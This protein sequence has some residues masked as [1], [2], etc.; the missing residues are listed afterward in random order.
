MVD[1][2][3]GVARWLTFGAWRDWVTTRVARDR[4]YAS[5]RRSARAA[6]IMPTMFALG[7]KVI[8]NPAI[9]TFAAFGS[10]AML[11][12]VDFG[13]S[14][15]DRMLAT[16][17]LGAAGCVLVALATLASRHAGTAALSMGIVAF[18]VLF[19]GVISSVLAGASTAL[20]LSIILPVTQ[21]ADPSV[22]PDRIAGW[23][24]AAAV[25]TIAVGV[26]WPSP[27]NDPLRATAV[28]ACRALGARLRTDSACRLGNATADAHAVTV[29]TALEAIEALRRGFLATPYR[30][31]GLS[32]SARAGVRLVDELTWLADI[33]ARTLPVPA[34]GRTGVATCAVHQAAAEV[35]ESGADL[36]ADTTGSPERL[37]T[38]LARLEDALDEMEHTAIEELPAR[39]AALR[40]GGTVTEAEDVVTALDPSFRAQ[41][42]SF[43]IASI[44][45][46]IDLVAA[47]DRRSWGDRLLGRGPR[48]L[49]ATRWTAQQRAG[50]HFERHSVW[51]HNSVRGAIALAIAV[52]IADLT[53]VQHSFWV[54]LGTLS[55][56]RSNALTTGQ[57]VARGVIGTAMGFLIAAALLAII[58]TNPT[59]LWC[60]LPLAV[61]LA[62]TLPAMVSFAAGQAAF[63]LVLV[64]LF[65]IIQ[66]AGWRVGLVRVEDIAIGCAV[67]LVVGLLF[68]PR[69]ATSALQQALSE[70]YEDS[71]RYL[72]DAVACGPTGEAPPSLTES[73]AAAASRRLDDTFR[74][75]L[76]ERGAKPVPFAEM[77]GLV[78]GVTALRLAADAITELWRDQ[79]PSERS[80][81][82]EGL[83]R[84]AQDVTGWYGD[85]ADCLAAGKAA[86]PPLEAGVL[87]DS[88]LLDAI[89]RSQCDV[90][91]AVTGRAIR[92]LWTADHLDAVRRL[93]HGLVGS[94]ATAQTDLPTPYVGRSST[95]AT[96]ARVPRVL[97]SH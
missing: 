57:T 27:P 68:W 48:G 18:V 93:Q 62:G 75:Y 72:L 84:A 77:S 4:D 94:T 36:M 47:A 49:P 70:A 13:G 14:R 61:L 28:A 55:V 67:S 44:G 83:L 95:G 79:T 53:G 45:G 89:R 40:G 34:V 92:T 31:T 23:A 11:L 80:D 7:D 82:Q 74:T 10:F 60:L 73:R 43:A 20:L 58:G 66:P 6:I 88:E 90:T 96:R 5:L 65:N 86:P 52:L 15:L 1:G 16:A 8:R 9:A 42:L 35:L 24:M 46:N 50:A 91:G 54:V 22:I 29:A 33:L 32:T 63:T 85:L 69:G 59:V 78:S 38:A 56:L 37:R 87:T 25:A 17:S 39:G 41:E 2:N 3:A 30:P 21:S 97:P 81:V 71:S 76:A 26:L 12:L 51:L 19:S 64:I